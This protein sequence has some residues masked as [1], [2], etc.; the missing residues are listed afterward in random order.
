MKVGDLVI[1]NNRN[2]EFNFTK[3]HEKIY[4]KD[5]IYV[6]I[7]IGTISCGDEDGYDI[8]QLTPLGVDEGDEDE[9]DEIFPF[10]TFSKYFITLDQ[11]RE[12]E[13]NKLGI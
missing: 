8:L 7:D 9:N 12:Q 11:W 5:Q 1:C 2:F 4:D 3:S 10:I 13:I 6:I